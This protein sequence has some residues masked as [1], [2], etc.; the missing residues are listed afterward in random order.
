MGLKGSGPFFQRSMI[1]KVL[2]GYVTHICDIYIDE[3]A[4]KKAARAAKAETDSLLAEAQASLQKAT[5]KLGSIQRQHK[6][7]CEELMDEKSGLL[8]GLEDEQTVIAELRHE[9]KQGG[10]HHPPD[11]R[12]PDSHQWEQGFSKKHRRAKQ[13]VSRR[14]G[15]PSVSV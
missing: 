5:A 10:R 11:Y 3:L 8:V 6:E 15:P 4:K 7:Q 14:S 2:A 9:K 1:N 12:S 13:E